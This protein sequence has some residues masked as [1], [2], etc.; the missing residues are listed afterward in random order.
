[1][2]ER[3]GGAEYE[4]GADRSKLKQDL[5]AA[6]GDLKASGTRAE[7]EATKSG[8]RALAKFSAAGKIATAALTAGLVAGMTVM[9]HGAVEM[10]NAQASFR[11]ETGA[12]AE[13]A[14]AWSK[15]VNAAAAS[16]IQSFDEI[17]AASTKVRTDLGLTGDEAAD[18]TQK[19]LTFARAT[20]QD[21][22]GAVLAFDDVLDA[23]GKTAADAQGIMDQLVLSHQTYGGSILANQEALGK[24]APQLQALNTNLDSGIGFLNLFAANGLDAAAAQKALNTAVTNVPPGTSLDDIVAKLGAIEDRGARTQEAIRIFGAKAG[25]GLANA[26]KPGMT[27]LDD[28]TVSAEEAAG[29]TDKAREALDSTFSSQ[30]TLAIHNVQSALRG[31]GAEFGPIF[32]GFA[33]LGAA[34][35]PTL[36]SG[37]QA[38]FV[39]STPAIAAAATTSGGIA[40]AA[41]QVAF[42]AG[43]AVAIAWAI[44]EGAR[45]VKE[46]I[47]SGPGMGGGLT[48]EEIIGPIPDSRTWVQKMDDEVA[49]AVYQ[50]QKNVAGFGDALSGT[51][52]F[53]KVWDDVTARTTAIL[54]KS[55]EAAATAYLDALGRG[56]T[57]EQAEAAAAGHTIGTAITEG[58]AAGITDP[59]SVAQAIAAAKALQD[60]MHAA[61]DA[62]NRKQWFD[63]GADAIA[64]LGAGAASEG[65]DLAT[66]AGQ[67]REILK[68]GVT[69]RALAMEAL[70]K[71]YIDLV[72]RGMDSKKPGAKETAQAVALE[73]IAAIEDAGLT[74]AK[75][76]K[77]LKRVGQLYDEL[78]ASGMTA[79]EI[80]ARLAGEGVADVVVTAVQSRN[81]DL[82]ASGRHSAQRWTNAFEGWLESNNPGNAVRDYLGPIHMSEP[83]PDA[84][85]ALKDLLTDGLHAAQR[86][87]RG[88]KQGFRGITE[89]LS[90]AGPTLSSSSTQTLRHEF[91]PLPPVVFDLRNVPAGNSDAG[92]AAGLAPTVEGIL[93]AAFISRD[94][95]FTEA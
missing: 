61:N 15:D 19:F 30:V 34:L 86:Y 2:A 51:G 79:S 81:A 52:T 48:F 59:V 62:S 69:P 50:V 1:M 91:G 49:R 41:F 46:G 55:G 87:G 29:A 38:M 14:K 57:F 60:R 78:L 42:V 21:A 53:G 89:G 12:S 84:P 22:S 75:G 9:T 63:E 90:L 32:A 28:W 36:V 93:R 64:A 92:I 31:I 68:N 13:E 18:M 10:Q 74:G 88:F 11:A 4:V 3:I 24:M 43:L 54:T 94:M 82:A 83:R 25:V 39:S 67:L 7:A 44:L 85:Q 56:L 70:G 66:T 16:N 76:Q 71:D 95:R 26:I 37:L 6:E 45:L 20:G 73:A 27:S 80:D 65:E 5:A 58:T 47:L 8:G 33:T 17:A 72:R 35:G 77:G 23:W 40:G